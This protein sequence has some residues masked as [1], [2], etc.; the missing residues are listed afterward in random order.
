MSPSWSRENL[1]NHYARHPGGKDRDCWQDL[2]HTGG[3]PVSEMDYAAT[4]LAVCANAWVC[5]SA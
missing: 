3:L 4:S 5:Y 2:L 1:S